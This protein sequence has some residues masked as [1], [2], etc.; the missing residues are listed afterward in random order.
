MAMLM[1]PVVFTLKNAAMNAVM[2]V[3][4]FAPK[5][6]GAALRSETIRW[7]T[8][9]TTTEMVIVLE[10]IAAVVTVPQKKDFHAFLKKKRLK[11]SGELASSKPEINFL[12][13]KMDAKRRMNESAASRKPFGIR[14]TNPFTTGPNMY[15]FCENA[16]ADGVAFG[17]KKYVAIHCEMLDKKP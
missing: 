5:M 1:A 4:M 8:M 16:L 12:N 6:N 3:P 11:R 13:S 2:V 15:H 9:G 7:A 10:R 14:A 17:W